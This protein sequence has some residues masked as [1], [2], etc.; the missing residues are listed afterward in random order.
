MVG[1]QEELKEIKKK[2]RKKIKTMENDLNNS[3]NTQTELL[4][5]FENVQTELVEKQ[6]KLEKM[7]LEKKAQEKIDLENEEIRNRRRQ[8]K[9]SKSK[10][11]LT[12]S[13]WN[14]SSILS[15]IYGTNTTKFDLISQIQPSYEIRETRGS[16]KHSKVCKAIK[17]KKTFVALKS[18]SLN[19]TYFPGY[20]TYIFQS[21]KDYFFSNKEDRTKQTIEDQKAKDEEIIKSFREIFIL[22]N[23]RECPYLNGFEYI[24]KVNSVRFL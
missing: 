12:D 24:V 9:K 20:S 2:L 7:E 15:T 6:N 16:Q 4:N 13:N 18:F 21:A 10:K 23:I 8:Q 17:D 1:T 14:V 11:T 5:R 22:Y 19:E 3:K